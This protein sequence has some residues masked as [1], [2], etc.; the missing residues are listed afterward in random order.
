MIKNGKVLKRFKSITE[1]QEITNINHI[2]E[3]I[4]GKRKSAGGYNWKKVGDVNEQF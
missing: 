3:V 4:N 1:A 2:S